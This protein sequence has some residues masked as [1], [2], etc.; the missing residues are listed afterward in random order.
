MKR[1]MLL[2]VIL[3]ATSCSNPEDKATGNSDSTRFNSNE[4]KVLNSRPGPTDPGS[5]SEAEKPDTSASPATSKENSNS[6]TQ[7]TNRSYGAG[8]DTSKQKK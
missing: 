3:Y 1:L 6:S 8:Q 5:Q 7:G 2:T 4:N